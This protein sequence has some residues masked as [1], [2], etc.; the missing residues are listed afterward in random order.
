MNKTGKISIKSNHFLAFCTMIS[1]L[2]LTCQPKKNMQVLSYVQ[3]VD[4]GVIQFADGAKTNIPHWND[5]TWTH[6]FFVRHAEKDRS[7]AVDPPLTALGQARAERLGR[8]LSTVGLTSVCATD[9]LR[10]NQTAEPS[11][12]R[13]NTGPVVY[14]V[15]KEQNEWLDSFLVENRGKKCLIVGHQD[16]IPMFLNHLQGDDFVFDYIQDFEFGHFYVVATK[17]VGQSEILEFR[18]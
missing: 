4:K 7:I 3:S 6:L 1:V 15:A 8:I 9:F 18:Y 2:L 13:A 11:V 5:P 14:Y 10:T 16:N 17:G 12:R